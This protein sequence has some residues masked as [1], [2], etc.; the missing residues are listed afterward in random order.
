MRSLPVALVVASVLLLAACSGSSRK[1]RSADGDADRQS[2]TVFV[3]T[4]LQGTIEPCGCSTDPLGDL[5]RTAALIANARHSSPAVLHLDGGS[6]LY[7]TIP[8]PA[9]LDAQEALKADLLVDAFADP[10]GTAAV[11]LGPYDLAKGPEA[12]RPA[13]HAVNLGDD[14][15]IPLAPPRVVDAGGVKVGVFGVVSPD[16]LAAIDGVQV[17]DPVGPSKEAVAALRA[18]G[19]R[20]VIA[21]AHMTRRDATALARDVPGI[22]FVIIGQD[23][24]NEPHRIRT[25]PDRIGDTWL[26]QPANRGQVVSRLDVTIRDDAGPLHDAIGAAR[27]EDEIAELGA[28]IERL[29]ADVATW[30][31]DPSS[32]PAFLALKKEELAGLRDERTAL[33]A[34]PVR[35]PDKG[36]WFVME[37]VRIRRALPCDVEV[38]AAKSAFDKAAGEAN[39]AAAA[40]LQA[41]EPPPGTA[42][43]AGIEECGY[44]H[45]D[46]VNFWKESRHALA[47][48]TLVR[49]HKE[50][51]YDCI[52][53]HVTGWDRPGGSTLAHNEGLRDVQCETCHGPGSIH[54]DYDGKESPKTMLRSPP[55][56][57]CVTCHN[58]EH[59]DTFDFEAYLR[60][61]T[62]P[63]HGEAFRKSLGDGPT[64]RE[65]RAAGLEK[66]GREV[67]EGCRK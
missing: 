9:H 38:Q 60:D 55:E 10:L 21:L 34:N 42:G 49:D 67:G 61:V 20:I 25:G 46:A 29:E 50:Y 40:G 2:F 14:A 16:A 4:E 30:E 58:E 57:L 43:Y 7:S 1:A 26:L 3:T 19:A 22:D 54:I 39:L 59:S 27:A 23:A 11:G 13:R 8:V 24:P 47:W 18:Q 33:A 53:C 28:R 63:G 41:P 35:A 52:S 37:Q 66:A 32:D 15:G 48:E 31:A 44:C 64:G 17:V 65:L 45:R 36:S 12:V 56:S 5:A 62:G 6:M 51:N